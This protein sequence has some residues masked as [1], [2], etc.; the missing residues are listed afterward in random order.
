MRFS[1]LGLRSAKRPRKWPRGSS[2]P[3]SRALERRLE[4]F[5]R[6]RARARRPRDRVGGAT[7]AALRKLPSPTRQRL[8]G[9]PGVVLDRDDE[10]DDFGVGEQEQSDDRDVQEATDE[11]Q[12]PL[13]PG[14]A[15]RADRRD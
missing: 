12:E 8:G 7:F 11:E 3:R 5:L 6:L 13:R 15:D 4:R 2:R 10:A 1:A 9:E 14:L